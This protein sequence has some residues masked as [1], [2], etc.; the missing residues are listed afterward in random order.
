MGQIH[1]DCSENMIDNFIKFIMEYPSPF[2][3][4]A[5]F[6]QYDWRYIMD[7]IHDNKL[8]VNIG[9]RTDNDIYEI[10]IIRADKKKIIMRDS[11]ALFNSSLEKMADSFCPEIPKLKI[12]IEHYDPTNQTHIEYAKRD[13]LILLTAMPKIFALLRKH[14]DIEPNATFAGTSLK[15]WQNT[16]EF[17]EIYNTS[18]Y[19][20]QELFIRQAYYGGIVFLTTTN[21]QT[22]CITL[23]INSSYPSI[24]LEYGVPYGRV[25]KTTD[26]KCGKMGIYRCRVKAPDRLV[27][28]IIPARNQAGQMRWYSGEFDTVCTNVELIFAA[29]H[30]Y[31]ILEIYEGLVFEEVI[32]PFEKHISHCR[33]IRVEFKGGPEEY[34]AKFMQNSLYGKFG[35][36]R[37]RRRIISVHDIS[38]ADLI[39]A[40]PYDD[41]GKW[42]V[43]KELDEGMRTLPEW[44]VFIT[45]H[46]RIKLL[47]A[48]YSA[49]VEN[50]YYG[51]TDSLTLKKGSE[52]LIDI[53]N[54][55]GQW[56]LEKTWRKF[57]AIAPK[58]YSGI[59]E[60]N[61]F[62]GAAKGLP[63]K[64]LGDTQWKELLEDG[65]TSAQALS[66]DSLRATLKK[67]V[68]PAKP[69]T[70]N[71]G[72]VANSQNF[73]VDTKGNVYVKIA[74]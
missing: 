68:N 31:E 55:Y 70:R 72:N 37:E 32:F 11:Y 56:K 40:V 53:G 19:N 1:F 7:Y 45:A 65:K 73:E 71:S 10:V 24:M 57:R 59:L 61:K 9:M 36:K 43:L 35:S 44:S 48:A 54:E 33:K 47:T 60:N 3:W 67:G 46:A 69:L 49:G 34:L 62:V 16:L 22:N 38:D 25:I 74:A 2:V 27:I 5:H 39:K 21:T 66:L 50:V 30:G 18:E 20:V 15:G 64:N 52:K 23:D 8:H 6:A 41:A 28:P 26:Y 58:I 12:D 4:Y 14:F 29:N 63:R 17:T 51:D 13:V 42:Y